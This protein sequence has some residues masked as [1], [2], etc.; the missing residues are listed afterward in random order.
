MTRHFS[1]IFLIVANLLPIIG[2]V[3][4]GWSV[5]EIVALYWFENVVIGVV[6]VLKI[7]CSCPK[8]EET[9]VSG[10]P[11][12]DSLRGL[13][14]GGFMNHA[15]K[16]FL[17]PFFSIHYGGF[18]FVHGIF[19]FALLGPKNPA[20]GD[21]DP[22][23]NMGEWFQGFF[24]S[25]IKWFA[26]AIIA[27]HFY[28]FFHNYIGKGEFRRMSAQD[29]MNAPYGRVV[30]LHLAIIIGGFVVQALGSSVGL[31]T[32]LIIGKIII[33]AKL[34]LRAHKKAAMLA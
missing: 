29:L 21:G 24:N 14:A 3:R 1:L 16:L 2:V 5:F 26:I 4:W 32:I 27:S 8:S 9:D 30:I 25:D 19:V 13:N 22:F 17:I 11:L 28:S 23:K 33:D 10:K 15:S 34:H 7:L 12:P 18:C 6:N 20:G 31:L